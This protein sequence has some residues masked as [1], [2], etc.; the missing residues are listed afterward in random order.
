MDNTTVLPSEKIQKEFERNPLK[1]LEETRSDDN[2]T[3]DFE[4]EE[5]QPEMNREPVSNPQ[6]NE[7][8]NDIYR[9]NLT[10]KNSLNDCNFYNNSNDS[11]NILVNKLNIFLNFKG[12]EESKNNENGNVNNYVYNSHC[13]K[14]N[15]YINY[16]NNNS[17]FEPFCNDNN[18]SNFLNNSLL[19][20]GLNINCTK[21][22]NNNRHIN[23]NK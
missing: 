20:D 3:R 12:K 13:Q 19:Y 2:S 14:N 7:D 22:V 18:N 9:P 16:K 21:N 8:I 6:E 4:E 23:I 10:C 15:V 5:T 1:L 11:Q 17:N